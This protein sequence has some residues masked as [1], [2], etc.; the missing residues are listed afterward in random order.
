[1]H[2]ANKTYCT[3]AMVY[4]DDLD[5]VVVETEDEGLVASFP[6]TSILVTEQ[7]GIDADGGVA[8]VDLE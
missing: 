5:R 8:F 3:L 2:Y 4:K 6:R 1:M 7:R